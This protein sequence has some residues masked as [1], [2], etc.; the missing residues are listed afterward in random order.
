[1]SSRVVLRR[2]PRRLSPGD[3]S[4]RWR[5]P[6]RPGAGDD[7]GILRRHHVHGRVRPSPSVQGRVRPTDDDR[8]LVRLRRAARLREQSTRDRRAL[9]APLGCVNRRVRRSAHVSVQDTVRAGSVAAALML[10]GLV[11]AHMS[12]EP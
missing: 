5:L 3:P 2:L 9:T 1:M 8:Y 12:A 7:Q 6:G 11:R 4:G 10:A